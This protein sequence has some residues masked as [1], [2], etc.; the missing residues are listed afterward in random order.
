M[1]DSVIDRAVFDDLRATAGDE[2][3]AEL[4]A[5]FVEEAPGILAELRSALTDA[6][7]D[8]FR[9]AA[10]SL[11]SN[12]LT[13]GATA[14]AAQARALEL[15]GLGAAADAQALDALDAAYRDAAAELQ[16]LCHG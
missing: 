14:L 5:T 12:A 16:V 10:H 15:G 3:V 2:F 13:F 8:R 6:S 1:V 11:K 9:R 7:A 4:A